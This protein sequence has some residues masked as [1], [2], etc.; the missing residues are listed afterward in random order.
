MQYKTYTENLKIDK[1]T[2]YI[3]RVLSCLSTQVYNQALINIKVYN[4]NNKRLF[5]LANINLIKENNNINMLGVNILSHIVYKAHYAYDS[6]NKLKNKKYHTNTQHICEP[7][8]LQRKYFSII[9]S[10]E[11]KNN[12]LKLPLEE[13]LLKMIE[14]NKDNPK[15][16]KKLGIYDF[17]IDLFK[18]ENIKFKIPKVLQNK[19]I[20][21]VTIQPLYG[22]RSF[23][24]CYT[25]ESNVINKI[26]NDTNIMAI[27]LGI[28]NLATCVTTNYKSFIVDGKKLK[29]IN[30]FYNKH[31]SELKSENKYVM[32]KIIDQNTNQ[33][34]YVKTTLNNIKENDDYK[35]YVTKKMCHTGLKRDNK[36]K[37]YIYKACNIIIRKAIQYKIGTIVLGYSK[38]FQYK[39]LKQN[40]KNNN[41][42]IFN[43]KF[44]MIPFG[45]IKSRLEYLAYINNIKLIIQEESFTSLA[46]FYD[47]DKIPSWFIKNYQFSGTRIKRGLY[48]T[49]C[50]M[51]INADVNGA[52]N[53]LK[54]SRVCSDS[55]LESIRL[56]GVGTPVRY[57]VD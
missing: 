30:Q 21:L 48:I 57:I 20:K 52:L 33:L 11:I 5:K 6:Y 27:D 7:N 18:K 19:N 24:I 16:L 23:K 40:S 8:I 12:Y 51:K 38:F 50:G 1:C 41:R 43:Q 26:N 3:L 53:I 36:I 14:D 42:K 56:R 29:S 46:S 39:G 54:K 17:N 9:F 25:Y 34:R 32:K 44:L 47:N 15:K 22:A 45:K 49:K 13:K 28:N 4:S 10:P 35:C 37:D 55:I 2:F 31:I